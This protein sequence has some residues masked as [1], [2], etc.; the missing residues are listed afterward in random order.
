MPHPV[1]ILTDAG[2]GA[3]LGHLSRSSAIAVALRCRGIEARCYALGA[4]A[5]FERD[6]IAWAPLAL[7]DVGD[8][9]GHVVLVDSYRLS[10]EVIQR[11]AESAS[12][13]LMHDHGAIPN[14]AAMIVSI[15]G[16]GD[17]GGRSLTGFEYAA[18]RPHFWGLPTRSVG[19]SAGRVLVTVGSGLLAGAGGPIA[20][21]IAEALPDICVTLVRGPDSDTETPDG[22]ETLEAPHS[23]L[24][25]LLD[26]DLVVSAAGQSM[27]EA[28]AAGTPCVALPL[29]DNQRRQAERLSEAGAVRL[30]DP[31]EPDA[32]AD[33]SRELCRDPEARRRLSRAGQRVVDGYGALRVAFAISELAAH[34]A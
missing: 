20:S 18:L 29:A 21:A 24:E 4:D 2:L 3:G 33:A 16:D 7:G 28:A 5:A 9:G 6:G 30:V 12:I 14:G 8:L 10:H 34:D 22:V 17:A 1:A 15:A 31:P 32:A 23:L 19:E 13:V 11:M 26:A 27:L 25:P